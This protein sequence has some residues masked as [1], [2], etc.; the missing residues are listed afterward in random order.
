MKKTRRFE[1]KIP[2]P[3]NRL[4]NV[5][6]WLKTH[7]LMFKNTYPSRYV[8]SLYL[9]NANLTRYEENLS[10]IS[11]RKKVR[12]RWYQ[13]HHQLSAST[14][15]FKHREATKGYKISFPVP[16]DIRQSHLSWYQHLLACHRQLPEQA[17]QLWGN[18]QLPI[19]ICR[20]HREYFASYCRRIR[21]TL[22]SQIEV[23]DQRYRAR[24]NT[25]KSFSLGQYVLLELKADEQFEPELSALIATCPLRPSRH[26]KYV[27]GLRTLTWF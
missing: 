26:S 24:P 3:L 22:D 16:F 9:D 17:R 27:I 10:G 21:A 13:H 14:L 6:I 8:S 19:L 4:H 15:E 12:I 2:I 23:F 25:L 18:E 1:V 5:L 7:P 20:Y 11:Q